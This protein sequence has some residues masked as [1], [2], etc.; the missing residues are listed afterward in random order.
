MKDKVDIHLIVLCV[1]LQ[2]IYLY[3]RASKSIFQPRHFEFDSV[4]PF[5]Q[6]MTKNIL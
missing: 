4:I 2:T 1:V 5:T 3:G 6:G